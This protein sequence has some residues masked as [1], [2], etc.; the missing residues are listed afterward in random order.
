M[1]PTPFARVAA[2][3]EMGVSDLESTLGTVLAGLG[4]DIDDVAAVGI[5]GMAES[6]APMV[7]GR[8]VAPVLAWFDARGEQ[9]VA[10][11]TAHF[12]DGLARRIGQR[13][14]NVSSVAK[15]G[16]LLDHGL[17]LPE[18]WLGVPELCLFLLTGAE[19]TEPSLAART[20]AYDVGRRE[21]IPEVAALLGLGPDLFPDVRPAGEVMGRVSDAA[22]VWYGLPAG[23]PVTLAGHDHLA[24]AEAVSAGPADLLNSVGTA[25]TLL[26]RQESLPD[27]GRALGLGL[28]VTLRPGG[29]GWVVLASATRS[30][31]VLE[32]LAADLGFPFAELDDLAEAAVAAAPDG[33]AAPPP[34]PT[35]RGGLRRALIPGLDVP[36]GPPGE[37]WAAALE[38]L[39]ARTAAAAARLGELLGPSPR[40]IVFGGGSQSRPWL[41]AKAALAPEGMAVFRAAVPEVTARGAAL[42]AGVA[43]GWWPRP[44]SGPG[45]TLEAARGLR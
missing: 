42:A 39:S 16:W 37:V 27:V 2:G 20:G 35:A 9:T 11:L 15:L 14:R 8:P 25:E 3:V 31:L 10:R 40:M 33:R 28:A 13:V 1:A 43:T 34:R 12:G 38:A 45:L 6:G 44:S 30:G 23:I 5:A 7:S 21:W 41:A 4:P 36:D 32:A 29:T 18:R 22:S 24:A 19:A 17:P 26:R